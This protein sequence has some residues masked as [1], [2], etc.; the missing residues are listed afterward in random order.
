MSA[1]VEIQL[2]KVANKLQEIG[3]YFV[4]VCK[5]KH[6]ECSED[7]FRSRFEEVLYQETLLEKSLAL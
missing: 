2:E 1:L 4:T 7:N 6:P 5:N 3:R